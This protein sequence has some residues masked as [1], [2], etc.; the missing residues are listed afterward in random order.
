[1]TIFMVGLK[2]GQIRRNLTKMVNPRDITG[3]TE[4]EFHQCVP[5]VLAKILKLM[6]GFLMACSSQSRMIMLMNIYYGA[7]TTKPMVFNFGE[8]DH[9]D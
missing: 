7:Q 8:D 3:N 6:Q 1:M 4:E 2:A 9:N 5:V